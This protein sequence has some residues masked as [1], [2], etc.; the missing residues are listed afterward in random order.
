MARPESQATNYTNYTYA[1][2]AS[3]SQGTISAPPSATF[4]NSALASPRGSIS[5]LHVGGSGGIGF[6]RTHT[7]DS[8][9]LGTEGKYRRKVG[10][11]AFNDDQPDT[12]FTF[13]CQVS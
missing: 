6:P 10:F 8:T 11:E 3:G 12:L 2:S 9:T 13:T 4:P 7:G 1:T 5:T